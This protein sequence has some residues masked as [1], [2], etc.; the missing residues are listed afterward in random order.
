MAQ[1]Y[2]SRDVKVYVQI[3]AQ[4]WDIPVLEGF[5]FSQTTNAVEITVNEMGS[6]NSTRGRKM[7]ND[8]LAPAEWS[9]STYAR[10]FISAGTA[11]ANSFS[12]DAAAKHH[13]VE[14][15][16]WALLSGP[17]TY[18]AYAFTAQIA[19][20][21]TE[22]TIDFSESN[23]ST[24]GTATIWFHFP[25]ATTPTVYKLTEACVNE[26]T[27]NFD[28][29][30]IATIDW[31]GMAQKIVDAP[32]ADLEAALVPT[33]PGNLATATK[34]INEGAT[35]DDTG[36]FI[37]NRLSTVTIQAADIVAF[38]GKFDVVNTGQ[39]SLVLT[40][41][42]ITIS[43]NMSFLTPSSLACVNVPLGHVTGARTVS[44]SLDCYLNGEGAGGSGQLFEDLIDA[45]SLT[46]NSFNVV[47]SVGGTAANNM[48][49]NFPTAHFEIPS[50][51]LADVVSLS[52]N[53]H[54]LPS[55][56]DAT[57]EVTVVYKG[58]AL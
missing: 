5:S 13:A 53:F 15:S 31:S 7:F 48:T 28:I 32:Y 10:P 20:T 41:G 54:A 12:A 29:D 19:P 45:T 43:N 37:R 55:S 18:A 52:T 51:D 38:P 14:E 39:Y 33:T 35:C 40:G 57:D 24:L 26:A 6:T 47:V 34:L 58:L 25:D 3:G 27:L 8:S 49:F 2:F 46:T 56:I 16:L 42:S 36:N 4:L 44:G 17:A 50:H 9:F 1:L 22:S 11:V 30:G 23:R 21:V